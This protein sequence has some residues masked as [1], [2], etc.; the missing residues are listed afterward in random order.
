[1]CVSL[2]FESRDSNL[3]GW[4]GEVVVGVEGEREAETLLVKLRG[5]EIGD[6]N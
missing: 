4:E 6:A 3:E 5:V 2:A 1:M